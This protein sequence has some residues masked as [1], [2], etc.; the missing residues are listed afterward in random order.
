MSQLEQNIKAFLADKN[1]AD[2]VKVECYLLVA[3]G[4]RRAG[5]VMVPSE[6]PGLDHVGP[7]I[8]NEFYWRTTGRRDPSKPYTEFIST[9]LRDTISRFG[10]K[11]L[12]YKTQLLREIFDRVVLSTPQYKEH[13]E[14]AF[15][16]GLRAKEEEVRPSIREIWIYR[17][18]DT[19]VEIDRIAQ[20]RKDLRFQAI[21]NPRP[22]APPYYRVFPEEASPE[23][24]RAVGELLGYPPSCLN[25]YVA[26]RASRDVSAEMRAAHQISEARLLGKEVSS[27]AYFVKDFFPC[28]PDCPEALEKGRDALSRLE[29]LD[30]QAATI[31]RQVLD[32]NQKRVLD[33]PEIIKAHAEGLNQRAAM[34]TEE[35]RKPSEK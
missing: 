29:K 34:F 3:L 26:D 6:L 28:A 12:P 13:I 4:V 9:K 2:R 20:M 5:L 14:W 33:Y 19:G 16:L 15:K 21:R 32:E 24:V 25:K 8:D 17:D 31:Y 18:A 23:Y 35:S 1:L 22:S 30:E 11:S 7:E 27:L 10:K